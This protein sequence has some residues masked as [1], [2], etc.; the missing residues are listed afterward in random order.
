[1]K[2][3]PVLQELSREHHLL[4]L[5][6]RQ[7]RWYA[8]GDHR[9]PAFEVMLNQFLQEWE[10]VAVPH[11][12]AEEQVLLPFLAHLP[13][14]EQQYEERIREEHGWLRRRV[15]ELR[16]VDEAA[17][18]DLLVEVG[19]GLHDHIR[20]EERVFFQQLQQA[21]SEADF[22]ELEARFRAFRVVGDGSVSEQNGS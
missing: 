15:A 2:R 1:V 18:R 9:A 22:A 4:L 14:W 3:H 13:L 7:V 20:F 12:Q 19:L 8:E 17:Q 21:L 10:A 5:Q 6:A 16:G 11:L